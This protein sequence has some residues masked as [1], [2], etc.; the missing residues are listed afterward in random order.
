MKDSVTRFFDNVS[1]LSGHLAVVEDCRQITY[2]EL[3]VLVK[4]I[5]AE[6]EKYGAQPRVV[7]YLHQGYDA[8]AAMI[9]T[10]LAGG[11]Y[12]PIK[13][14]A[15]LQR[16]LD[17]FSEFQPDIVISTKDLSD[18]LMLT[19][20]DI[21]LID[22]EC[23]GSDLLEKHVKSHDLAYVIFTSG[24]T[25]KPKGVMIPCDALNHYV[26]WAINAMKITDK[27]RWS[28]HPNI[29]FDLSVLDI[30]GALCGGATLYPLTSNKDRLLPAIFIKKNQLTIWNSVPSVID[31]MIRARQV[32]KE[33]FNS[34]RLLT[35]CGEPLLF[36]HVQAIFAANKDAV[37]NN[38]YGP[39]EATV[40]CTLISLNVD[41][42]H[43]Y[44]ERSV[45]LGTP[46][47]GMKIE[48]INGISPD[49]GEIVLIG[50][51]LARG[52]W[53][54]ETETLSSFITMQNGISA[55]R[56]G[57]WVVRYK[58]QLYFR[59]RLDNQVKVRGN[60]VELDEI[61]SVLIDI[62]Y[63]NVCT[64]FVDGNLYCFIETIQVLDQ[65]NLRSILK[66]KLPDYEIPTAVYAIDSFPRNA[67]DKIDKKELIQFCCSD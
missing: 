20:K 55:Y 27:D 29:A 44:C 49:E 43:Q 50:P 10:L 41:N 14:G 1:K 51:Q 54:N 58:G 61:D 2:G 64:I 39:T 46:I 40:S 42:Y 17:V 15:P 24:S 57:D 59:E 48:L 28:Q 31:L 8:Y 35:F 66:S 26:E 32:K 19:N 30:Y 25:G 5:A 60:R 65:S 56:T 22:I 4:K 9:A 16:H 3:G 63:K 6:I 7:I 53:N 47:P 11:Y 36:R 12:T 33:N 18:S 23:L 45:A 21:A 13:M 38:T 62:G 67:N 52:Y 37:V 34:L